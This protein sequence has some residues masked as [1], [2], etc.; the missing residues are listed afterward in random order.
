ME[1]FLPYSA[2]PDSPPAEGRGRRALL[3]GT[4]LI[5]IAGFGTKSAVDL[6]GPVASA[7]LASAPAASSESEDELLTFSIESEAYGASVPGGGAYPFAFIAEVHKPSSF[8]VNFRGSEEA[9]ETDVSWNWHVVEDDVHLIGE[10]V[11]HTF[12]KTGPC[13]LHVARRANL[14][15]RG[16]LTVQ[17]H[18]FSGTVHVRYVKREL[19]SMSDGDRKAFFDALETV[20]F[21]FRLLAVR[22]E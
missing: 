1:K 21:F 8:V 16:G 12:S 18:H 20:R 19:R 3:V 2:L 11:E 9:G 14:A 15:A 17:T 4:A 10:R 22:N 6:R 7:V 5:L 13:E